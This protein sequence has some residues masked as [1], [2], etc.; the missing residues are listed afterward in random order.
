M[1]TIPTTAGS[2][3]PTTSPLQERERAYYKAGVARNTSRSYAAAWRGWVAWC[4]ANDVL[5]AERGG[6]LE[7][8][9][10]GMLTAWITARAE[11]GT[12]PQTIEQN[13]AGIRW[14]YRQRGVA[15]PSDDPHVRMVLA[16]TKREHGTRPVRKDALT[17]DQLARMTATA[18]IR[19][20]ALLLLGFAG[21]F[22]RS[23][24]EGMRVDDVTVRTNGA[25]VV[26]RS[27]KG[28]RSNAGVEVQ[29]GRTGNATCP[30]GAVERW[31]EESRRS[32][33]D[34]LFGV[35]ADWIAKTV[36][37]HADLIGID[38]DAV[39]GHS[40]R[41]GLITTAVE[42]GV[43]PFSVAAFARH[44]DPRQ[45]MGYVRSKNDVELAG[46]VGL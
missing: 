43:D 38:P 1:I 4:E 15:I 16:G 5:C 29:V 2:A 28:D 26:L 20:R 31:L 6:S 33:Q 40:L 9:S 14:V 3:V 42:R 8:P 24:L 23:E 11:A 7:M 41:A 45:T 21:A 10:A 18:S 13:L 46:R 25:T 27:S 39:A 17:V 44:Q 34:P 36:K 19:D 22:R 35:C 12:K 32:G 30:V 37:R